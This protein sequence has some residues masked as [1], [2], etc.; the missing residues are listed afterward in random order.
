MGKIQRKIWG[1]IVLTLSAIVCSAYSQQQEDTG[2][3]STPPA[4]PQQGQAAGGWVSPSNGAAVM[5]SNYQS[6]D[7]LMGD[8]WVIK[9][10]GSP[11]S[12]VMY[13]GAMRGDFSD[14]QV[15]LFRATSPDGLQWTRSAT[16]IVS[17][18][19]PGSW[20]ATNVETPSVLK[21]PD[22]SYR[23]YYTGGKEPE[24]EVYQIGLATSADGSNWQKAADNPVLPLGPAGSFDA[25][26]VFNPSALYKDGK[27]W[28][29][30]AGISSTLQ[31]Q[32][33]LALSADGK[34]WEKQ[35][36]VLS[37]DRERVN[38]DD[39]GVTEPHVLWNGQAFEMW[40]A[41]LQ[42]EGKVVGPIWHAVSADGKRWQKD[43]APLLDLGEANQW[44]GQG[45]AAPSVLLEAGVYRLWYVGTHTDYESFLELGIGYMTGR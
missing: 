35:G 42:H 38:P 16:P 20:D 22:G 11:A 13:Y 31:V 14:P 41:V 25:Y 24:T 18:G 5:Q 21:L 9:D 45:V 36:V 33:G 12:Y 10:P 32:I 37:L 39:A 19:P 6:L 23:L 29:W 4:V 34:Q 30:Y 15:R 43:P 26:S 2:R 28:M 8:P 27:Y 44:T 40:Y 7:G 17:P 3:V 1:G